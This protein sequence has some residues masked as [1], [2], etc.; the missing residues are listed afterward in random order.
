MQFTWNAFSSR[1]FRLVLCLSSRNSKRNVGLS[2]VKFDLRI[3]INFYAISIKF[4][5]QIVVN[6]F[7]SI[8]LNFNW[9]FRDNNKV[10]N[11]WW[12]C[13]IESLVGDLDHLKNRTFSS[14]TCEWML[15]KVFIAKS[16]IETKLKTRIYML[17]RRWHFSGLRSR[18]NEVLRSKNVQD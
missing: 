9:I 11:S 4:L 16:W 17:F 15:L 7:H 5:N 3:G 6:V 18:N 10:F 1:D 8:V 2:E 14:N 12:K 13:L